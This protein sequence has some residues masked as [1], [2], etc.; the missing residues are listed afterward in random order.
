MLHALHAAFASAIFQLCKRN[1]TA[2][3][4]A[5]D[6]NEVILLRY[7][8]VAAFKDIQTAFEALVSILCFV[9]AI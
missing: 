3:A 7:C 6:E 9:A 2:A 1:Q 4:F 8:S 5:A